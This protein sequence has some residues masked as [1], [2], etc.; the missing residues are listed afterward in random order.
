MDMHIKELIKA[1]NKDAKLLKEL[2][3]KESKK[4][5]LKI[6]KTDQKIPELSKNL[7]ANVASINTNI[8]E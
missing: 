7:L 5:N 6:D 3:A 2:I 8:Q 4:T 1:K